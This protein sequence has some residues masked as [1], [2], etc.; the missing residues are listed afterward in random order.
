MASRQVVWT[1]CDQLTGE[2]L[3]IVDRQLIHFS[4]QQNHT[5]SAKSKAHGRTNIPLAV[6]S[7]NNLV[8]LKGDKD[9]FKACEKY[10]VVDISDDLSCELRKFTTSQFPS[11]VYS[12]LLS[13][14]YPVALTVLA[15]SPQGPFP[16]SLQA[17]SIRLQ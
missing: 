17:L 11:K 7:V 13:Q 3:P 15:Q 2:Q 9:K 12:V 6:V 1:Q 5:P 8:F 14:C 16:W 4:P 10:L